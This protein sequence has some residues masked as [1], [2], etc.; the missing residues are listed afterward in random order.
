[1][2]INAYLNFNGRCAEAF[3]FYERCL[4]GRIEMM[5]TFGETPA[6]GEVP[7]DWRDKVIHVRLT[8]GDQVLMG[9][10]APP[11]HFAPAQGMSVSINVASP[12]EARRI[13]DDLAQQGRVTM[14]FTQTFWSAGFGM[15]VD[16]FGTPWMV[17]C[18][19]TAS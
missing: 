17:N 9:S 1:M 8:V 5:Q 4:G 16:R 13:F 14:P 2:Q 3:K 10:D 11:G 15:A 19:P 6:A 12:D 7:G 18:Q